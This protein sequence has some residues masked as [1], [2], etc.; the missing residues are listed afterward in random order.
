MRRA[1]PFPIRPK[2]ANPTFMH[3]MLNHKVP[4]WFCLK[5]VLERELYNAR[6]AGR[7]TT[8]TADVALNPPESSLI[9]CCYRKRGIQM[10]RKIERFT[11]QLDGFS[12]GD[13]KR[14][15]NGQIQL[16]HSGS[17]NGISRQ[18]AQ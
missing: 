13:A 10:I 15:R 16:N 4:L 6:I 11:T 9:Y 18:V 12:L 8:C 3:A 2:P 1:I 14:S 5:Y 17:L 7:Q